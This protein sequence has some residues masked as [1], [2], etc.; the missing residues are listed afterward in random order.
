VKLEKP[1]LSER[2][3]KRAVELD[4]GYTEAHYLLAQTYRKL[5]RDADAAKALEAFKKAN[6]TPRPRR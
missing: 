6:E 1:E 3:L 5:G 2:W 4:A